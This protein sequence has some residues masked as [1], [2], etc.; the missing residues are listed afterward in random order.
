MFIW[1]P[2]TWECPGEL[3]WDIADFQTSSGTQDGQHGP[4][5][6]SAVGEGAPAWRWGEAQQWWRCGLPRLQPHSSSDP[7]R[8]LSASLQLFEVWILSLG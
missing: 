7:A 3:Q 4:S 1:H 2:E 8:S 6:F 5:F